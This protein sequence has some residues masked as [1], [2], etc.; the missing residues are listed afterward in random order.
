[1]EEQL[2]KTETDRVASIN[3]AQCNKL[4]DVAH[5]PSFSTINCPECG[6]KQVVPAQ[7]GSFILLGRLGSGGMGVIYHAQDKELGRQ[8]ALKVMKKSLGENEEFVSG[9]KREARAAAALNHRNVV[10]IYSFG[11][12]E[13]Q[14]YIVMELVNGGRLD[15]MIVEE[16]M[17]DEVRALEIHIEVAEGLKAASEVGL[18]HG[19]VKPANILF[20]ANGE[21]KV[22]DFGLASFVGQQEDESGQVWGTPYYIA[23]EKARRKKADFRSDI[24]SLGATLFH[25]LT[26]QPPFDGDTPLDVVLARL[27]SPAP[28]ILEIREDLHPQTAAMVARMLEMK[29]TMRYPSYPALLYDMRETLDAVNNSD[30]PGSKSNLVTK[31]MPVERA[32][33]GKGLMMAGIILGAILIAGG[34]VA[35]YF[36]YQ[37]HQQVVA[38][39][40]VEKM[41]FDN[42]KARGMRAFSRVQS[43]ASV[44]SK[45]ADSAKSLQKEISEKAALVKSG[46]TFVADASNHVDEVSRALDNAAETMKKASDARY[47]LEM[48]ADSKVAGSINEALDLLAGELAGSARAAGVALEEVEKILGGIVALKEK[49]LKA[50]EAERDKERKAR[51]LAKLREEQAKAAEEARKQALLEKEEAERIRKETIQRELDLVDGA[52]SANAPL[53][54]QRKFD[55]AVAA[56]SSALSDLSMPE[57]QTEREKALDSLKAL[58][59]LKQFLVKAISDSSYK[60]G[61]V[62]GGTRRDIVGADSVDGLKIALGAAG[63]TFVAWEQVSTVQLLQIVKYYVENKTPSDKDKADVLFATALFCYEL[64]DFRRAE[65]IAAT[66]CRLNPELK[67]EADR[68]MTGLIAGESLE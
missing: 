39:A 19:D 50:V 48:A 66:A 1:M 35:G 56:F 20:G 64:G 68:L 59:G 62:F 42:A 24:Y 26:G 9:F 47:A 60:G 4:L 49:E 37:K 2:D 43:L 28:N 15:E 12:H 32:S 61:W 30:L 25:T 57:A 38:E 36:A 44:I 3:C 13:G 31:I 7:F 55:E 34:A 67:A 65:A 21:A 6:A 53:I 5:L 54:A 16:G 41:A 63:V 46:S 52:R 22:V 40:A 8:V 29:P 58:A 18:V 11:Q 14:P 23:P 10:Q 33:G 45:A 51:E 27:N 17:L